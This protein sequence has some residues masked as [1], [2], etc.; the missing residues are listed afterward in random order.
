ML[1]WSGSI[2]FGH[3]L[4]DGHMCTNP[5]NILLLWIRMLRWSGPEAV[6]RSGPFMY[7]DSYVVEAS[8]EGGGDQEHV[9]PPTSLPFQSQI[10]TKIIVVWLY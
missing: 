2:I 10:I 3:D 5:N 7:A 8:G 9:S 6:H 1:R 4:R